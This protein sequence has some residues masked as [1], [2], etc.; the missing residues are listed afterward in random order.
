MSSQLPASYLP[1]WGSGGKAQYLHSSVSTLRHSTIFLILEVS[2]LFCFRRL[3]GKV[4]AL[5]VWM[6]PGR[7]RVGI[8][9]LSDLADG[10]F[11]A[12]GRPGVA[13]SGWGTRRHHHHQLSM[14][15]LWAPFCS[16][17]GAVT[18][19]SGFLAVQAAERASR[20]AKANGS[21]ENRLGP[22]FSASS[23]LASAKPSPWGFLFAS[24]SGSSMGRLT[25]AFERTK[26]PMTAIWSWHWSGV[27]QRCFSGC[28]LSLPTLL[29][30]LWFGSKTG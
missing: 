8:N 30:L 15:H 16:S 27:G 10:G 21:Q 6:S 7:G 29:V 3:G 2:F 24:T 11:R 13:F 28:V 5:P 20:Q 25:A 18:N 1:P 23:T 19:T 9:V 26:I 12:A 17:S 4:M 22:L 14:A